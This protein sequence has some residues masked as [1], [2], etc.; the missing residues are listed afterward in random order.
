MKMW[1][2]SLVYGFCCLIFTASAQG[3]NTTSAEDTDYGINNVDEEAVSHVARSVTASSRRVEAFYRRPT[4][5]RPLPEC[6]AQQ[7]CNAVFMRFK[8][9]QPK[10]TCRSSYK[11][12]CSTRMHPNDGHTIN[13]LTDRDGKK[14]QTLVKVCEDVN[15]MK[16]C[17]KPHDWMLF[18]LQNTRTGNAQYLVLCKCPSNAVM[19][20][21]VL[22]TKP[23]YV[24]IPGISVYG[25]LCVQ[26]RNSRLH[27]QSYPPTPWDKI[28]EIYHSMVPRKGRIFSSFGDMG[29]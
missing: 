4:Y 17:D 1:I 9:V 10:C 15:T 18:A 16:Y 2:A 13:L 25:M 12:P 26:G 7:V 28:R 11:S 24:R 20:G 6:T 23:P 21:P 29:N 5:S 27:K 22:H 19:E 8:F 3:M 14:T